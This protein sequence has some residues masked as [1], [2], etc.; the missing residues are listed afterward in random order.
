MLRRIIQRLRGRSDS[1]HVQATIRIV[2]TG[3]VALYLNSGLGG[4]SATILYGNRIATGYFLVSPLFLLWIVWKPQVSIARRYLAMFLEL[5]FLSACMGFEGERGAPL[6][7]VY[8]WVSLGNGFRFGVR[9][10]FW[11]TLASAVGF[12]LLVAFCPFWHGMLPVAA[13][14]GISIVAIPAYAAFLIVQLHAAKSAAEQASHSKSRFLA[15]ASHEL[16][17]PLHAII[18]LSELLQQTTL[19]WEQSEMVQTVRSSGRALL[20]LVEDVL[21][22]SSIQAGRTV[23]RPEPFAVYT[24]L[25][26]TVAIA[27]PQ[28]AGKDLDLAI[29]VD[30]AVPQTVVG[31]WP[32]LRQILLNLIVNAIKFTQT[33]QVTLEVHVVAHSAAEVSL[34]F[35]VSDTG[36]GISEHELEHIF[37]TFAQANTSSTRR[38]GGVGLGLSIVRQLADLLRGE[39]SVTSTPGSGSLFRLEI[40]FARPESALDSTAELLAPAVVEVHS[41]RPGLVETVRRACM[42]VEVN[43]AGQ[44]GA[45]APGA[46]TVALIDT[47]GLGREEVEAL[48]REVSEKLRGRAASIIALGLCDADIARKLPA[49]VSCLPHALDPAS[50]RACIRIGRSLATHRELLHARPGE[51]SLTAVAPFAPDELALGNGQRVLVVEDSPVNRMVTKKILRSAGYEVILAETADAGMER[52]AEEDFHLILLDLNLP[53]TSGIEVIK[54][55]HLM[56]GGQDKAPIVIFSADVTP[57]ARQDCAELGV[58]LF[59]P[60]PSEPSYM[61]QKLSELLPRPAP[62]P[63][64]APEERKRS[65]DPVV[66]IA[67][68]PRYKATPELGIVDRHALQNLASLDPDLSFLGELVAAF[69]AD[70]AEVLDLMDTCVREG[71]LGLF[72]DQ[73]HAVRSSAANIGARQILTACSEINAEKKLSFHTRGFEYAA[74]LRYEF[75]RFGKTM[76][77]FLATQAKGR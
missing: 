44:S 77:R 66:D 13:G 70:T 32:H 30:P 14:I 46:V 12:S 29:R 75:N 35:E 43:L 23:S 68:H 53:V 73:V 55:Y 8:V 54:M 1:E 9:P 38:Y 56:R 42:D 63:Q 22:L 19:S 41:T 34:S 21:D 31:D 61:L 50:L 17:T 26:E 51:T 48:V 6:I 52:L 10:M 24:C 33:G 58:A 62:A 20:S 71:N 40:P 4:D 74:R 3:L 16:R 64:A 18:G 69:E 37:D 25:A 67:S 45:C 28:A 60:K 15:T 57:Q 11:S 7:P 2:I 5:G 76:D 47:A 36:I 65:A 59:L 27:R 39:V 72:W 49:V